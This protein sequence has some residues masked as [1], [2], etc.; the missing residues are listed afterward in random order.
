MIVIHFVVPVPI[1]EKVISEGISLISET[2]STYLG[3]SISPR[4]TSISSLHKAVVQNKHSLCQLADK[5][6][7]FRK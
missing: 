3:T 7:S 2:S 6:N 5:A 4:Q 1:K